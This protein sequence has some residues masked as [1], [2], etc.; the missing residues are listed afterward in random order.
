MS[1]NKT[2]SYYCDYSLIVITIFLLS[3]GLVMLYS[4][5]AYTAVQ[6]GNSDMYYFQRQL[7][8]SILG[9]IAMIIVSRIP[10]YCFAFVAKF[11]YWLSM[12]LMV[13]VQTP[14]GIE[15][16]GARR[17]IKFPIIGQFQPSEA[18]KVAVIIFIPYLVCKMGK[19]VE[20][21]RSWKDLLIYGAL[22]AGGVFLLTDNLSTAVIVFGIV[23][24]LM[25][26]V[27][28]QT[29]QIVAFIIATA[30]A[31]YLVLIN[32][33]E[34][35]LSSSDS[36]RMERILV[37]LNPEA[38]SSDGGYQVL[39][40]LYAI[41]SGG[42]LGKG[43]GNGTQKLTAI[44]EVQ[45]DYIIAAI[46]EELGV[47]GAVIILIMF[48]ILLYRL[49]FI[50]RNAPDMYGSLIVAGVFIHIALQVILNIAVVTALIPNTGI[51]LPFISYGGTAILFLLAEIG[52][53]LSV[54]RK[55]KIDE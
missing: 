24:G 55:I 19:N 26:I 3:F 38:Y 28:P 10:Y 33:G 45:N 31:I 18:T 15:A 7:V 14:L 42:W 20:D 48:G 44:P 36:F 5:S 35:L 8:F 12:F 25:W 6:E 16:N 17:W 4:I 21:W 34:A 37:W 43:L 41:G 30:G 27:L 1:K 50:S 53:A 2:K 54:S 22:A 47:F 23:L 11:A 9:L 39:Q 29:T 40:G 13:L 52:I 49:F 51:T 32:W 46:I